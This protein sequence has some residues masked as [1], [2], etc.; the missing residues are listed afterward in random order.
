MLYVLLCGGA[1][2]C[3]VCFPQKSLHQEVGFKDVSRTEHHLILCGDVF[4]QLSRSTRVYPHIMSTEEDATAL[5]G[6]V[7]H[8]EPQ[9]SSRKRLDWSEAT[10]IGAILVA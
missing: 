3:I 2:E 9:V 8:A 5:R 1:K 4:S 10:A 7:R 6:I